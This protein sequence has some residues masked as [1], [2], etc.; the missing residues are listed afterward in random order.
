M[1]R[2]YIDYKLFNRWTKEG[3]HF[4]TRLKANADFGVWENRPVPKGGNVTKDRL[5]RLNPFVAGASC[6]QDL[7]L[8][9]VWDEENQR[10]IQLLTN[11]MHLQCGYHRG[12]LQGALSN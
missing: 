6:R 5:I 2:G 7:R 1:D 12:Y 4:V 9:S 8:V 11:L 10:E 3:I